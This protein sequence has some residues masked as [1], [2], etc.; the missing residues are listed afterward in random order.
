MLGFVICALCFRFGHG[1]CWDGV[2]DRICEPMRGEVCAKTLD[3]GGFAEVHD[4]LQFHKPIEPWI[5]G[6]CSMLA[7]PFLH[8]LCHSRSYCKGDD[9]FVSQLRS[10]LNFSEDR[11]MEELPIAGLGY[12]FFCT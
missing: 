8:L 10:L 7:H 3:L 9:L 2:K 4:E 6:D 1:G 5:R 11:C 12:T